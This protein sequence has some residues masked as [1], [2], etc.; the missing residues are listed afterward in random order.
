VAPGAAAA[1]AFVVQPSGAT[2]SGAAFPVQP[3]VAVVDAYGNVVTASAAS[4]TLALGG[5]GA[6]SGCTTALNTTGG[7][8]AFAG[9]AVS[10]TVDIVSDTLSATATGGFT[11]TV[12]SNP[13]NITAS[14]AKLVYSTEPGGDAA[15]GLLSPQP[16]VAVEDA[17]GHLVTA[18]SASVALSASSGSLACP[19]SGTTVGASYG[20]ATFGACAIGT[21]GSGKTLT[22]SSSSLAGATSTAV[23]VTLSAP[24]ISSPS[25]S[26]P[27]TLAVTETAS[28][29]ITGTNF[30]QGSTVTDTGGHFSIDG[31]TVTNASTITVTVTCTATGTDALTV[32]NPDGGSATASG[33]IS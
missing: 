18:S 20:V 6:L 33:S 13:F 10:G 21:A 3:M 5:T 25:S 11:A 32:T 7:V 8:A 27:A 1:V 14:A 2:A 12:T 24:T 16:A 19:A 23:S 9:C 17:S 22:A 15:T 28:V 30:A 29:V 26:A 4:V 31:W